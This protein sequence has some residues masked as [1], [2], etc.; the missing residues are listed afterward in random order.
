M[1]PRLVVEATEGVQID[2]DPIALGQL[3][4]DCLAGHAVLVVINV[5]LT[6]KIL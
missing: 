3:R 1:V 4:D 5:I 2:L 6:K